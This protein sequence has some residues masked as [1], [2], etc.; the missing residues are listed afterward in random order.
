MA[1]AVGSGALNSELTEKSSPVGADTFVIE[2]SEASNEP[3][4]VQFTNLPAAAP[5][6]HA[7]THQNGGGDEVATATPGANAIPKADGSGLLDSWISTASTSTAGKVEL[8]TQGEMNTGTD[9]GRAPSVV[10][11]ANASRRVEAKTST[12]Y[13]VSDTADLNKVF[14]NEAATALQE[15][16]L[17]SAVAGLSYT[18]C[19]QDDDDIKITANTGNTIRMG[20]QVTAT[21]DYVQSTSI[22]DSVTLIA[23]NATEW[24]AVGGFTGIWSV[25]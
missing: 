6:S 7:S 22:G 15:F 19:V 8:A 5:A 3:K 16:T 13:A 17:P 24:M 1:K 25:N 20:S 2:D 9:T 11:V 21:A 14:T 12:P 10:V 4:Y 23:I 18:F